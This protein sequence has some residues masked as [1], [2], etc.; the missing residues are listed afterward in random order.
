MTKDRLARAGT[1]IILAVGFAAAIAIYFMAPPPPE[2]PAQYGIT[3]TKA[4]VRQME[5]I[6]GK[7][8][9]LAL[10]F[11]EWCASLWHGQRL[12]YT[13]AT[14]TVVGALVFWFV[15][16]PLPEHPPHES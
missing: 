4:D 8:N 13:V 5:L 10:Q 14:L 9:I 11:R 12:A 15:A 1:K 7:A 2:D 16:H 6:G 3:D